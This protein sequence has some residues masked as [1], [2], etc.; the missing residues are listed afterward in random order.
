MQLDNHLLKD[1]DRLQ[2]CKQTECLYNPPV[3]A[4]P[5][6][7]DAII[8]HYTAMNDAKA[9]VNSLSKKKASGNNASA[10]L[11]I[12]KKG[13]IWQL[14]PFNYRT[15][16]AGTSMY[17][18]RK[19]YNQFS[20]GIEIDNLG[21]LDEYESGKY[22][23]RP[24]LLKLTKPI[25]RKPTE[26]INKKHNNPNVRKV[27]WDKY[28]PEQIDTVYEICELICKNYK[29]KEVLGH[30]EIAPNRKLDPGPDFPLDWLRNELLYA[31][32]QNEDDSLL[33]IVEPY[34]AKVEATKLNIRIGP[35]TNEPK[36]AQPLLFGTP[37]TVI[38]KA[39]EWLKVKTEIEGWVHSKYI[40]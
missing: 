40:K 36:A 15:W 25:T 20:I 27:F 5:D 12:G 11:V 10:H 31:D 34:S 24:E 39:G 3:F 22:Y 23:S 2:K 7:P 4:S 16:H 19:S 13:E 18:G 32:R 30:E 26:V 1:D 21:W 37:V 14:A 28:T 17:N 29:I 38:N 35:G 6:L 33:D 9:A 8:I